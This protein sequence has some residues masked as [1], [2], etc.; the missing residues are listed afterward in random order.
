[1]K[2]IIFVKYTQ[3]LC[4]TKWS[5]PHV[6]MCM[7]SQTVVISAKE[8]WEWGEGVGMYNLMQS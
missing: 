3:K 4:K 2:Y 5:Q 8:G 7:S 6:C 1:L